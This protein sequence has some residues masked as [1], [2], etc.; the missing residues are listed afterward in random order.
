M[1]YTGTRNYGIQGFDFGANFALPKSPDSAATP[2]L[3][4][5]VTQL[6]EQMMA[7]NGSTYVYCV[8]NGTINQ[9]DFVVIL[10]LGDG[11]STNFVASSITVAGEKKIEIRLEEV[12]QKT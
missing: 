4:N 9:D 12:A 7:T 11:F 8:A 3:P 1:A 10:G 2:E 5:T 6:G